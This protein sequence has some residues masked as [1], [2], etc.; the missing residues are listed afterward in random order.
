[1]NEKLPVICT[2]RFRCDKQWNGLREIAGETRVRYCTD[3]IKPVFLCSSYDEL[4]EHAA[5][6]HCIALL[7]G[8]DNYLLGDPIT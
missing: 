3:C 8:Q 5:Q 1:M 4:A 6:S 2:F 7:D